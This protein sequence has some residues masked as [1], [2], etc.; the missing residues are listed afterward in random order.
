MPPGQLKR[1]GVRREELRRGEVGG[2]SLRVT[3]K[4]LERDAEVLVSVVPGR[5]DR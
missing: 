3:A 5:I 4:A 2:Q 1:P